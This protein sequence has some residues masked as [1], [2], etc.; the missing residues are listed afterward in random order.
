MPGLSERIYRA[1]LR[2]YPSD[3]RNEYGS[4]MIHVFRRRARDENAAALWLIT[5]PDIALTASKEHLHMLTQDLKYALRTL[6][7][8]PVFSAA[9]ILTLALGV[10]ANTAIFSVVNAVML[11]PLPFREPDRLVR[12]WETNPKRNI[13]FFSASVLNYLSWKEKATCFE[14]IGAFG[15]ASLNLTGTGEPERLAP[16]AA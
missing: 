6:R 15:G 13:P 4:E 11:R 12:I 14:S 9:A 2:C 8:P 7:R 16:G 1:L 5:V 10:G 3:F